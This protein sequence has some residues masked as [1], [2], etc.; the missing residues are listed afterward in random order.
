MDRCNFGYRIHS[1]TPVGPLRLR[2]PVF[3][4]VKPRNAVRSGSV[5]THSCE[6]PPREPVDQARLIGEAHDLMSVVARPPRSSRKRPRTADG[7]QRPALLYLLSE[8][9]VDT[10]YLREY[11]TIRVVFVCTRRILPR[12]SWVARSVTDCIE[13]LTLPFR[14]S[15]CG[16]ARIV[17]PGCNTAALSATTGG[18]PCKPPVDIPP[19][20]NSPTAAEALGEISPVLL[21][22]MRSNRLDDCAHDSAHLA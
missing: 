15:D 12:L 3:L 19:T 13:V 6:S 9:S 22:K 17:L 4:G 14:G 8:L 20:E 1:S 7:P 5:P 10:E 21:G 16:L 2:V 18:K 11:T